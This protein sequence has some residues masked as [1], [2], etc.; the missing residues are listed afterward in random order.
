M[1]DGLRAL[2]LGD[3][4]AETGCDSIGLDDFHRGRLRL[5]L[6]GGSVVMRVGGRRMLRFL[7]LRRVLLPL[8]VLIALR[9]LIVARLGIWVCRRGSLRGRRYGCR[10]CPT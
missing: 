9:V 2:A 7:A 1:D 6:W 10:R 5:E 3:E 8:R 4:C